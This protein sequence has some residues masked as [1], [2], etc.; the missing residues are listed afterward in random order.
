M[1]KLLVAARPMFLMASLT[2]Y[3][4]GALWAVLV[5]AP[6]SLARML[7]GYLIVLPA[8]VSVSFSNDYFDAEVDALGAP[9]LFS[10]GSGVLVK[11]PELR[12]PAKRIAMGL[13]LVSWLVGIVFV[14][15]Y[16]VPLWFMGWVVVSGLAGWFYSAPPLRL[17]Y[18]GWGELTTALTAG[19]FL[20]GMGYLV[21]R[22]T[23]DRYSMV[24]LV[25]FVL[26]GLAFIMMV[27]IPDAVTDRLGN[28]WTWVA[29]RGRRFGFIA[30]GV[31]LLLATVY[32]LSFGWLSQQV[33]PLDFR[34][35][36]ALSLLPLGVGMI[37]V[38][39]HPT[40]T[41]PATRLV[42]GFI[43]ALALFLILMD[44]YLVLLATG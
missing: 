43:S 11:H 18:R 20:P 33:Y 7:L 31:V 2:L 6:F 12:L 32:L 19:L 30:T 1:R 36:G 10:G 21:M 17:A 42:N 39:K 23:F 3:F 26:F 27:E 4:F 44:G 34:V 25:P 35:L 24:F 22:G 5:G 41:Q 38:I 29:R 16:A 13:I 37:G 28:K 15:L 14:W 8:H 9:T 40:G